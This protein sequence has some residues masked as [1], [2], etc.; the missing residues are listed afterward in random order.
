MATY[1]KYHP[2]LSEIGLESDTAG[3]IHQ[4]EQ[5][6]EFSSIYKLADATEMGVYQLGDALGIPERTLARRKIKG[7]LE[8]VESERLV[9]FAHL[10]EK[11]LN[12]A[13]GDRVQAVR[14]LTSPK[15]DLGGRSPM[16][17]A[18]TEIGAREV[19][20]L[21]GRLEHGVFS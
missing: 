11:A 15:K 18:K 7:K 9:R 1:P 2:L 8:V 12:L 16:E 19:E 6:I 4:I 21:I 20:N 10:Y 5:G 3:L 17:Y 13:E 14:W